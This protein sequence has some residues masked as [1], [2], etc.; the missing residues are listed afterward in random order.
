MRSERDSFLDSS[1]IGKFSGIPVR[2][3]K[4][5]EITSD[6]VADL[7][8]RIGRPH[9]L[10]FHFGSSYFVNPISSKSLALLYGIIYS[11][12]CSVLWTL[13]WV[14]K[15]HDD[16][17]LA[18]FFT[19]HPALSKEFSVFWSPSGIVLFIIF[20]ADCKL[21]NPTTL[22]KWIAFLESVSIT[23]ITGTNF[24]ET[25]FNLLLPIANH[26]GPIQTLENLDF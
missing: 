6:H 25:S 4:S 26:T 22:A 15:K 24:I 20:L 7:R 13:S 18:Y 19:I 21:S 12:G 23:V 16:S 11:R 2:T 9:R 5:F 14:S 8:R 3:L 1:F 10:N 17:P